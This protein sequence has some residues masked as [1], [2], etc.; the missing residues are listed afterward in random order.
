[1]IRDGVG[2]EEI[3]WSPWYAKCPTY[4]EV[5]RVVCEGEPVDIKNQYIP[6]LQELTQSLLA[7]AVQVELRPEHL[8]L[9]D[10]IVLR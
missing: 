5:W 9:M 4:G 1:M 7:E 6:L 10:Q 8:E 3:D 2:V